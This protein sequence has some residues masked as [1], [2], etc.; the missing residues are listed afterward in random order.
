M[1]RYRTRKEAEALGVRGLGQD[2]G[3]TP[4]HPRGLD[5]VLPV[6]RPRRR[7]EAEPGPADSVAPAVSRRPIRDRRSDQRR[8]ADLGAHVEKTNGALSRRRA[9]AALQSVVACLE[10]GEP[11]CQEARCHAFGG[12][13]VTILCGVAHGSATQTWAA[14]STSRNARPN[15][16]QADDNRAGPRAPGRASESPLLAVS[17]CV[18]RDYGCQRRQT[19]LRQTHKLWVCETSARWSLCAIP[20]RVLNLARYG[21]ALRRHKLGQLLEVWRPWNSRMRALA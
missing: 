9:P 19:A 4:S 16:R 12:V 6:R 17:L 8:G 13:S 1:L 5:S 14:T 20:A 11:A 7:A 10:L 2:P 3:A 18:R 15:I 21:W